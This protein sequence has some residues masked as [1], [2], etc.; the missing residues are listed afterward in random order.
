MKM[1]KLVKDSSATDRSNEFNGH[2]P[3]P[4]RPLSTRRAACSI[5]SNDRERGRGWRGRKESNFSPSN[6]GEVYI[7]PGSKMRNCLSITRYSGG[8]GEGYHRRRGKINESDILQLQFTRQLINICIR[9]SVDRCPATLLRVEDMRSI[10]STGFETNA[11]NRATTR[12]YLFLEKKRDKRKKRSNPI[13]YSE[14]NIERKETKGELSTYNGSTH[15]PLLWRNVLWTLAFAGP[16]KRRTRVPIGTK[17]SSSRLT[18]GVIFPSSNSTVPRWRR[19]WPRMGQAWSVA[20]TSD[21]S[22]S[23][24]RKRGSIA[25]ARRVSSS[26]RGPPPPSAEDPRVRE[27]VR[28][29]RRATGRRGRGVATRKGS[30]FGERWMDDRAER[31]SREVG[32]R[33]RRRSWREVSRE[34]GRSSRTSLR[35][36]RACACT[37]LTAPCLGLSLVHRQFLRAFIP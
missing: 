7:E 20:R 21:P 11:G 34:S 16:R 6:R 26:D 14:R 36:H 28:R 33:R 31:R 15:L 9:S 32:R 23:L 29:G 25:V 4:L 10:F 22:I 37:T 19:S 1:Q 8:R 30:R 12:L 2:S 24:R 13:E 27:A 5:R 18:P 35:Y 17:W 3:P